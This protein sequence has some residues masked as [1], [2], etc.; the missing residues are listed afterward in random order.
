MYH[1]M[2]DNF[3]IPQS[4]QDQVLAG[5]FIPAGFVNAT[6]MCKANGKRLSNWSRSNAS[7]AFVEAVSLD[8]H[9]RAS[10]LFI[11]VGGTPNG[12]PALQ[13]TY[14]HILIA[15][16][17]G[18]WISP[19]FGIWANKILNKVLDPSFDPND[20]EFQEA[21]HQ[22]QKIWGDLRSASK[23]AFW[24]LGDTVKA[25]LLSGCATDSETQWLYSNCQ[26]AINR[27][28]FG[29][30][31]ATIREELGL[32]K[33]QLSRD[34]FNA[35]ALRHLDHIQSLASKFAANGEHPLT[36]IDSAL[37]LYSHEVIFYGN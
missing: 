6:A 31:A 9:I 28:L 27:G 15:L 14:V 3:S 16:E 32:D 33:S 18:R 1:H 5:K 30:D 25:Y 4:E 36:A 8:T 17:V 7:I 2:Y 37:R 19:Q 20:P 24:S 29:K 26:N 21:R 23:E 22:A 13:G 34:H 35:K 10:S 12:D 11:E